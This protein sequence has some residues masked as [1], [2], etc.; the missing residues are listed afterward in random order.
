MLW[1]TFSCVFFTTLLLGCSAN[2]DPDADGA[3]E[4]A[5]EGA[6]EGSAEGAVEGAAEGDTDGFTDGSPDGNLISDA[7]S[8]DSAFDGNTLT[9]AGNGHGATEGT[10]AADAG[11]DDIVDCEERRVQLKGLFEE[12]TYAGR[13]GTVGNCTSC[14]T[15]PASGYAVSYTAMRAAEFLH[16][17][18]ARDSMPPIGGIWSD[19][20]K[21]KLR[22]WIDC[23]RPWE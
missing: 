15:T 10:A 17:K 2:S 9:D 19:E 14:H 16:E 20:D 1:R 23:G 12:G 11:G 18:V 7:G 6:M 13:D 22:E 4:G 8:S 3:T 5:A 21:A